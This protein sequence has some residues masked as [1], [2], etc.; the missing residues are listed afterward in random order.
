MFDHFI[1]HIYCYSRIV[2]LKLNKV[3]KIRKWQNALWKKKLERQIAHYTFEREDYITCCNGKIEEDRRENT[4]YCDT[5]PRKP[6]F[7]LKRFFEINHRGEEH[8]QPF[9]F[10]KYRPAHLNRQLKIVPKHLIRK[11]MA[12]QDKNSRHF[13]R[14]L[15][16]I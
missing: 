4:C 2:E 5:C 6:A 13:I 8:E 3:W 1:I 12:V 9:F 16:I 10:L 15:K 11:L 14:K 7:L